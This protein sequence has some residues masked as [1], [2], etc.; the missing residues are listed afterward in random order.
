MYE[1]A[2]SRSTQEVAMSSNT[3]TNMTS[4][5]PIVQMTVITLS[6]M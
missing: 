2:A 5:L 4:V 6:G 3:Q 1:Q